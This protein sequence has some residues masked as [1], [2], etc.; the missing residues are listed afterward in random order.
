MLDIIGSLHCISSIFNISRASL[1]VAVMELQVSPN[2]P[3]LHVLV[4]ANDEVLAFVRL[5]IEKGLDLCI[6]VIIVHCKPS[7]QIYRFT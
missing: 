4:Y 7:R 5:C 6:C 1:Q 3:F 2:L